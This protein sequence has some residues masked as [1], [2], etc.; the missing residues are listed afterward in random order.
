MN[1]HG[2]AQETAD[3]IVEAF[4]SGNVAKAIAPIFVRR[5]DSV[6]CRSWSWGN[7]LHTILHDTRDACGIKQWNAVGRK[8]KKGSKSF[9]ILVPLCKSVKVKDNQTG[10]EHNASYLYGFKTATGFPVE[11]TDGEELPKSDPEAEAWINS[12]PLLEVALHGD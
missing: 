10:E 11:F 4:R 2:R 3:R 9:D 6:P 12:L 5:K 7:Q 8:V 1:Y